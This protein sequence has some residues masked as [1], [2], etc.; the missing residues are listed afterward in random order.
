M[1]SAVLI[2]P[3]TDRDAANALGEA[4]G[5]GPDNYSVALSGNGLE[6]PTH[7]GCRADV[8]QSF[9]DMLATPP[10]EAWPVLA[11]LISDFSEGLHPYEHWVSVL[12]AHGLQ[13]IQSD[14]VGGP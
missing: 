2:V 13:I 1:T 9:I 12:E 7:W 4:M 8:S 5:W 11:V 10:E 3:A 6:P 14:D